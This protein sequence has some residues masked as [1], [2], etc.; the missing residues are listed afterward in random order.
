MDGQGYTKLQG[1]S[2]KH[3]GRVATRWWSRSYRLEYGPVQST[4]RWH[5]AR[6]NTV[7]VQNDRTVGTGCDVMSGRSRRPPKMTEIT[8]SDSTC[9]L[10][11]LQV[12]AHVAQRKLSRTNQCRL[13]CSRSFRAH[14]VCGVHVIRGC[15]DPSPRG[16]V[17]TD[18]RHVSRTGSVY[19]DTHSFCIAGGLRPTS[20]VA[21][22]SNF[23]GY[24]VSIAS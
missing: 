8:H 24:W 17:V 14:C 15:S 18:Q 13:R 20:E 10:N 6:H 19:T 22:V 21:M 3:Q 5:P 23:F 11:I 2:S 1:L 4:K 16:W 7:S 12:S 9:S